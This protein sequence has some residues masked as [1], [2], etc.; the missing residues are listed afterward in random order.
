MKRRINSTKYLSSN[1][2]YDVHLFYFNGNAMLIVGD[3]TNTATISFTDEDSNITIGND[4]NR[5]DD[6]YFH[7]DIDEVRIGSIPE[8]V[9][10]LF[11]GLLGFL[12][13]R[14]LKI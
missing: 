10:F 14:K 6:R 2:W 9:T 1:T 4:I 12:A 11:I 8:P 13:V 3:T 7:G 5:G